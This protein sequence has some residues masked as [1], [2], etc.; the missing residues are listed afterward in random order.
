MKFMVVY[1]HVYVDG[2]GLV[3]YQT[4]IRYNHKFNI[5]PNFFLNFGDF[6]CIYVFVNW[7]F[8]SF[9]G[10]PCHC[11]MKLF[12]TL[13]WMLALFEWCQNASVWLSYNCCMHM[14]IPATVKLHI[15]I[16]IFLLF[17][18]INMLSCNM[19]TSYGWKSM[20][21]TDTW[22]LSYVLSV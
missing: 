18:H 12:C 1:F 5:V 11:F 17:E 2:I 20:W 16:Y 3:I 14:N 13:M 6:L 4:H 10:A 9:W 7:E 15:R 22:Y 21:P 19:I 8:M